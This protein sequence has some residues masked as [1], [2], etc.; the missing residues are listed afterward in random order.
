MSEVVPGTKPPS[1]VPGFLGASLQ[2]GRSLWLWSHSGYV[3]EDCVSEAEALNLLWFQIR[4]AIGL[5]GIP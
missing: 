4:M 5:S 1:V 3:L 2:S